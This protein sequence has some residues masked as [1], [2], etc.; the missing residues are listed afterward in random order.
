MAHNNEFASDGRAVH[1][2]GDPRS[3]GG[4]ACVEIDWQCHDVS[5]DDTITHEQNRYIKRDD[6]AA[7]ADDDDLWVQLQDESIAQLKR[8]ISTS[9]TRQDEAFMKVNPTS[10]PIVP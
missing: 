5:G 2:G 6:T 9:D 10:R 3:K 1:E 4:G 8:K 7:A